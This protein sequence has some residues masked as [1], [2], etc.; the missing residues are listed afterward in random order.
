MQDKRISPMSQN[1]YVHIFLL[2]LIQP[3]FVF[4]CSLDFPLSPYFS[5]LE[6]GT[7]HLGSASPPPSFSNP[8][9]KGCRGVLSRASLSNRFVCLPC[10]SFDEEVER[11]SLHYIPPPPGLG[12]TMAGG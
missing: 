7:D 1:A 6:G 9:Q 11:S 5:Q 8:Y 10:C 3:H 4:P 12:C 2:A